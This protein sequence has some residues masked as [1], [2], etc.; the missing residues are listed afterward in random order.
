MEILSFNNPKWGISV[1]QKD[2]NNG[3]VTEDDITKSM[4]ST[5][6]IIY[7]PIHQ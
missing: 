6:I 5:H 4:V 7:S 2:D 3:V 1:V